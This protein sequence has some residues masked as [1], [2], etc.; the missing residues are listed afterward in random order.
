[1]KGE[2]TLFNFFVKS[3]FILGIILYD[4]YAA[5][6]IRYFLRFIGPVIY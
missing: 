5:Q 1:M 6:E 3:C 4:Q 2:Y